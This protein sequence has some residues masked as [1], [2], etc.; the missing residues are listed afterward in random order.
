MFWN[1]KK[2]TEEKELRDWLNRLTERLTRV[3]SLLVEISHN[4]RSL[5]GYAAVQSIIKEALK[6]V[7]ES[8]DESNILNV[9]NDKFDTVILDTDTLR[10]AITAEKTID[11]FDD[12][13]TNV[14]E[15]KEM[16]QEFKGCAYK[17]PYSLGKMQKP[18]KK[19]KVVKKGHNQ[20]KNT[21]LD[22]SHQKS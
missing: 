21:V 8:E 6:D 7:F 3:E 10:S 15:L 18:K 12:Y 1:D 20:D 22:L 14:N 16:M 4:Q 13:L 19:R 9:L 11:K 5:P 17:D 2:K